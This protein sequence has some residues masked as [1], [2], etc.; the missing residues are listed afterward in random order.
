MYNEG[1]TVYTTLNLKRQRVAQKYVSEGLE[2]QDK[3]SSRMNSFYNSAVDRSLFGAYNSLRM[4]FSLPL[5]CNYL[6]ILIR[7]LKKI[8]S[9]RF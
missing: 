9:T 8:W 6:T 4:I 5:G 3:V 2:E 1:L 7:N